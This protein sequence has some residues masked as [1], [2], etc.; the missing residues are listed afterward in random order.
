M[1]VLSGGMAESGRSF[2]ENVRTAYNRYTWTKLPN[3]VRIEK[4]SA[5]YDAGIIGAAAQCRKNVL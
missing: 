2:I 1:I 3:P 5:G 4:A